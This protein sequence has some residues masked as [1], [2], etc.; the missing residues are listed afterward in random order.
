M[1]LD[2]HWLKEQ[3]KGFTT[4]E[5]ETDLSHHKTFGAAIGVYIMIQK[6]LERRE[7]EDK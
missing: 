1:S 6:E 4:E 7:E 2:P 5:L 3:F